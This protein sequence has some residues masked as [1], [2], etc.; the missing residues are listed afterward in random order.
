MSFD[1]QQAMREVSS[2]IPEPGDDDVTV[3]QKQYKR[4]HALMRAVCAL[5]EQNQE[6]LQELR[7]KQEE[8]KAKKLAALANAYSKHQS[9][10]GA[11]E[12]D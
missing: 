8:D 11:Y 2:T 1:F 10:M 12:E 6:L 5:A 7:T 3:Q 9:G 4:S